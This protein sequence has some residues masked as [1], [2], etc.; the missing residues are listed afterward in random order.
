M[1]RPKN[2]VLILYPEGGYGTFLEWMLTYYS[3]NTDIDNPFTSNGSAHRFHGNPLDFH[4]EVYA[5]HGTTK[6]TTDDYFKSDLNFRFA[7]VH[8]VTESTSAQNYVDQ[9]KNLVN[10][11][12]Y[13]TPGPGCVLLILHNSFNKTLNGNKRRKASAV[14]PIDGVDV[15]VAR[16]NIS[17][18]F[19][20]Y[21]HY[22]NHWYKVSQTDNVIEINIRDF[23]NDVKGTVINLCQSLEL[24]LDTKRFE[25][26]D[27]MHTI[28]QNLQKHL[29]T[30][31]LCS[32]II[33]S[34]VQ[35]IDLEWEPSLLTLHDEAYIQWAL[36]DLHRLD[37]KCYNL[38]VFPAST[39]ELRKHLIN[40]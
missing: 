16:E 28:W 40:E 6:I 3:G 38:N 10:K 7:R 37:L 30:D 4:D 20:G 13:L 36:R 35:D 15:W 33:D 14:G 34:V 26:F 9:Y 23:V 11:I 17:F 32:Q 18:W 2:T 27:K 21:S 39:Q 29:T 8:G 24:T 31:Q 12:I 19:S 22:I 1:Y 5:M 25:Q